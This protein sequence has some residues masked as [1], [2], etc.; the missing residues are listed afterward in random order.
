M[1]RERRRS[2]IALRRAG[3]G[4]RM[5]RGEPVV[6]RE[7]PLRLVVPTLGGAT[8]AVAVAVVCAEL[9]RRLGVDPA[10]AALLCATVVG[11]CVRLLLGGVSRAA[12]LIAAGLCL[13]AALLANSWVSGPGEG[14]GAGVGLR[15]LSDWVISHGALVPVLYAVAA[16][17]AYGSASGHR[18]A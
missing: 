1:A 7:G 8:L 18:A 13:G 6:L 16:L 9:E 11:V 5:E 17:L 15:S 14:G 2:R 4:L 12:G 3:I 10:L